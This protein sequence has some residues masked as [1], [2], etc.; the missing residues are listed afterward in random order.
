MQVKGVFD[1]GPAWLPRH[2]CHISEVDANANPNLE[3]QR[4][5]TTAPREQVVHPDV[6]HL[7]NFT[8]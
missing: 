4:H 8:S 3:I 2:D 7:F 1:P 6:I 5:F